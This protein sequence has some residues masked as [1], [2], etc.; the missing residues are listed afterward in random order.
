MRR[1]RKFFELPWRD[2]LM[3]VEAVAMTSI[4]SSALLLLPFRWIAPWLGRHMEVSSESQT[5]DDERTVQ[6]VRTAI[7]IS[8]RYIWWK[9]QC[10][11]QAI[12][13]TTMLRLRNIEGTVY[14]GMAKDGD[15][16]LAAHAWLRCGTTIVTG[17]QGYQGQSVV[18]TFA[19]PRK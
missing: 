13:A 17:S 2:K 19:F 7:R 15:S 6:R 3:L 1:L 4:A 10:L 12:A 11:A 18:A 16:V 8:S 9:P 14:L 5:A